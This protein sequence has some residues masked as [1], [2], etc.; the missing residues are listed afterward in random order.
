M[1]KVRTID[2]VI[3]RASKSFRAILIC[4]MRQVGKTT[5]LKDACKKDRVYVT[6]DNPKDLLMAKSEPN[7]FFETY[8]PPVFIDEIL[9]S[10]WYKSFILLL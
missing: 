5:A 8:K 4:G 3:E 10:Q 7:F 1:N 6:L 2:K 9:L